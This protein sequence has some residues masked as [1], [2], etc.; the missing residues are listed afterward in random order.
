MEKITAG[1]DY[2]G[3]IAPQFGALNDDV[4][5]GQVWAREDAL[6]PRDRS[7]ITI[8][9]LMGAGITDEAI[10]SHLEMGLAHGLTRAEIVEVVTQLAFY[11]GW[12]K[13]WAVF[14]V[15]QEV[16]D[17]ADV[18]QEEA[19][20]Y[21]RFGEHYAYDGGDHFTGRTWMRDLRGFDDGYGYYASSLVFEPGCRNSW[22]IHP[23]EQTLFVIQGRGWYVQ[24]GCEPRELH[25]GDVVNIPANTRHWHGAAHDS[26]FEHVVCEDVTPGGACEFTWL[27]PVSDEEYATLEG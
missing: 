7:L 8:A 9:A 6:S 1:R 25:V 12:P 22:H 3:D 5:F 13:G 11:T 15:A 20:I 10:R 4:L 21:N 23:K 2:L 24:E 14:S 18:T 17:Q 19:A 27:E 16:F 26:W